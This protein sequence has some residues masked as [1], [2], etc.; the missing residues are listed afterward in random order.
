[1]RVARLRLGHVLAALAAYRGAL[2]V[3]ELLRCTEGVDLALMTFEGTNLMHIACMN[4]QPHIVRW[5]AKTGH[6][7]MA[8]ALSHDGKRPLHY[9]CESGDDSSLQ[10]LRHL[11][12]RIISATPEAG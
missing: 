9:A 6:A 2:T 8:L 11:P 1:M 4:A 12:S 10:F 5:L 7:E 3:L